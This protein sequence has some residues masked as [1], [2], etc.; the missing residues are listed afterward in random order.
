MAAVFFDGFDYYTAGTTSAL[1]L[2][3]RWTVVEPGTAGTTTLVTGRYPNS[4]AARVR[5]N[6]SGNAST[7]ST[8]IGQ[9]LTNFS[10]GF[11]IKISGTAV[12][13]DIVTFTSIVSGVDSL[14]LRLNSVNR[15]LQLLTG[16]TVLGTTAT[17]IIPLDTWVYIEIECSLHNTTGSARL[18]INGAQILSVPSAAIPASG[19][20][21]IGV[22]KFSSGSN[23]YYIDVDDLYVSNSATKLG[24]SRVIVI[25]PNADTAQKNFQVNPATGLA[26]NFE[27]VNGLT[28]DN[29]DWVYGGTS[30]WKDVYDL[31]DMPF[32]PAQI[33]GIQPIYVARKDDASDMNVR[34][35][36]I[37]GAS[38]INGTTN[39]LTFATTSWYSY[40]DPII[41]NNPVTGLPWKAGEVNGLKMGPEII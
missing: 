21:T 25:T 10:C 32:N 4:Q 38:T 9:T 24:E 26:G 31:E 16:S 11:S 14:K 29:S 8:V 2:S 6:N 27:A 20:T 1:P 15:D 3:S 34:I 18:Y 39:N 30:G 35:N 19:D 12:A 37:S 5:S 41:Y 22:V 17:N 33:H 7:I 40:Y 23:S 28:V 13:Y 36:L